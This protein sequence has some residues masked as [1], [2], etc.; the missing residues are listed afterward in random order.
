[1][2]VLDTIYQIDR[3]VA[4]DF[5]EKMRIVFDELLSQRDYRSAPAQTLI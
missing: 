4:D 5:K 2:D 3:K 1:M